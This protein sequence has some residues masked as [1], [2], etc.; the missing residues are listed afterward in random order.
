MKSFGLCSLTVALLAGSL[1]GLSGCKG[2]GV[3][4]SG[5][6]SAADI[7]GPPTFNEMYQSRNP[8]KC[9]EVTTPPTV[10]QAM[11]LVQCSTESDTTGSSTPLITLVTD[12]QMQLGAPRDYM[13][14]TDGWSD[15]DVRAKVYPVRGQ[16]TMWQCSPVAQYGVGQN[17]VNYPAGPGGQGSCY[18]TTFGDWTCRMTTGSAHQVQK[19]KGPTTY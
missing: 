15:I 6:G 9:A 10:A 16:G 14:G 11:A 19:L 3:R 13:A 5:G 8:R 7:S 18:K 17:C 4:A 12:L 2:D 1:A